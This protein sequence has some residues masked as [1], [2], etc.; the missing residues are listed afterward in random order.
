MK[1]CL[2]QDLNC[3]P[4]V[5]KASVLTITL[6]GPSSWYHLKALDLLW[7]LKMVAHRFL[8]QFQSVFGM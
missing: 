4:P 2:C 5:L 6:A 8:A 7:V 1:I 3:G